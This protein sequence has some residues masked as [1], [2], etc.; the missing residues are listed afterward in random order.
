MSA[1]CRVYKNSVKVYIFNYLCLHTYTENWFSFAKP[2][3]TVVQGNTFAIFWWNLWSLVINKNRTDSEKHK[4]PLTSWYEFYGIFFLQI[5]STHE[6]DN[7]NGLVSA[8]VIRMERRKTKG[9]CI[10]W[11]MQTSVRVQLMYYRRSLWRYWMNPETIS[12][13]VATISPYVSNHIVS[14]CIAS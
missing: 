10:A 7:A 12:P 3:V 6:D 13:H 8:P 14:W 5:T 4:K 11:T 9:K 2:W 1:G